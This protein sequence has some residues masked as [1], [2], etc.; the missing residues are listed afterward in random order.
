MSIYFE[1]ITDYKPEY[2][3][4]NK[5]LN[6]YKQT[7]GDVETYDTVLNTTR[8]TMEG[9]ELFSRGYPG[10]ITNANVQIPS[11][12]IE[13]ILNAQK[14]I[15]QLK[16]DLKFVDN[17]LL[18]KTICTSA[19]VIPEI[20][21]LEKDLDSYYSVKLIENLL[22]L[23][24]YSPAFYHNSI[25]DDKNFILYQGFIY[26][27]SMI[28]YVSER[29]DEEEF[30]KK[31][32]NMP[33]VITW[34]LARNLPDLEYMLRGPTTAT[35]YNL[36]FKSLFKTLIS[37]SNELFEKG[38]NII[39][40]MELM[41]LKK[42]EEYLLD[43]INTI[44]KTPNSYTKMQ[45][46]SETYVIHYD[47]EYG[48]NYEKDKNGDLIVNCQNVEIGDGLTK[49]LNLKLDSMLMDKKQ[50]E[51]NSKIN[52][53]KL[54]QLLNF[55]NTIKIT[56]LLVERNLYQT[57]LDL[58]EKIYIV[59]P[60]INMI[61][62]SNQTFNTGTLE[63]SGRFIINNLYYEFI[64][65]RRHGISF[66][67]TTSY[68]K[69][70]DYLITDRPGKKS[71]LVYYP[72]TI[73]LNIK[74]VYNIPTLIPYVKKFSLSD[75]EI[76]DKKN[77]NSV[78]FV[79]HNSSLTQMPL[80]VFVYHRELRIVQ[81]LNLEFCDED[82]LNDLMFFN[83]DTNYLQSSAIGAELNTNEEKTPENFKDII[84]QI[85]EN[86]RLNKMN[87]KD[88][89]F[90]HNRHKAFRCGIDLLTESWTKQDYIYSLFKLLYTTQTNNI[91][92]KSAIFKD[93]KFELIN[94]EELISTVYT[95]YYVKKIDGTKPQLIFDYPSDQ[96]KCFKVRVNN[97]D[98]KYAI[99]KINQ[100]LNTIRYTQFY[101]DDKITINVDYITKMMIELC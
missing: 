78:I 74:D 97:E 50:I 67:E 26:L 86:E 61:S 3:F 13:S 49:T 62:R 48:C 31:D 88:F 81:W 68:V 8:N 36:D 38:M 83:F 70:V 93:L 60:N 41:S 1:N 17:K 40:Y 9:T 34:C 82:L 80:S 14:Q 89:S 23:K 55:Y 58:F 54:N 12:G 20:P 44:E 51:I 35:N 76:L 37:S 24:Q 52:S 69:K 56:K 18:Y 16:H 28:I 42:Q 87:G 63:I 94:R 65:D 46:I 5:N 92:Y 53:S 57:S 10:G 90:D 95:R 29:K 45:N 79:L 98:K 96:I 73:D 33:T 101:D 100:N 19:R 21:L 32:V 25:S 15:E 84:D 64:P 2:K 6:I 47:T 99:Q 59:F 43:M 72:P 66:K 7:G 77:K 11:T 27:I 85:L 71:S 30:I 39:E 75:K 91:I 4:Q 22:N